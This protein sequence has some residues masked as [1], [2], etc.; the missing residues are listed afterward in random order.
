MRT[1]TDTASEVTCRR[2][3]DAIYILGRV[4]GEGKVRRLGDGEPF[5]TTP[6]KDEIYYARSRP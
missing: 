5:Q 6:G 4:E 1:T 3:S 2:L